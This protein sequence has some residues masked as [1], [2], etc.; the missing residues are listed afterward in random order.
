[1]QP[2]LDNAKKRQLKAPEQIKKTFAEG[3]ADVTRQKIVMQKIMVMSLQNSHLPTLL[4][5]K[6]N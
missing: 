2:S 4:E 3:I 6:Y 5:K 1:L